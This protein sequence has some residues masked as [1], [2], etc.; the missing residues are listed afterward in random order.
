MITL[1]NSHFEGAVI[2]HNT[3]PETGKDE[4]EGFPPLGS[5]I[6]LTNNTTWVA[7]GKSNAETVNITDS[8]VDMQDAVIKADTWHSE[9]TDVLINS[10]SL[11]NIGTGSGDMN[12]VIK[13]DGKELDILGK[14]IIRVE[15]G[16][17]A[18]EA[19]EVDL[20][21]YKYELKYQDGKWVLVQKGSGESENNTGGET[22]NNTGGETEN[23]TGGESENETGGEEEKET[24]STGGSGAVLSNSAN[25]VLSALAA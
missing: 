5:T 24:G 25:A 9:N 21:A 10:E 19:G 1:D 7:K 8:T 14:E 4:T 16:E 18:V 23:N 15:S 12:V 22:E 6:N 13:S 2:T 11:L 3:N 20:G 17:M